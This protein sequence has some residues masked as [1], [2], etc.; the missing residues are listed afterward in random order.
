[1]ML[2]GW[3][4]GR[5]AHSISGQKSGWQIKLCDPSLTR[6]ILS[7]LEMSFILSATQIYALTFTDRRITDSISW[8]LD[9]QRRL[10]TLK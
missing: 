4:K 1:M 6:A 7:A 10:K 3:D 2:C 8:T 5:M 9:Q